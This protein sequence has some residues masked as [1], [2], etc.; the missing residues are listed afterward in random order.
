MVRSKNS[1]NVA[2]KN[3]MDLCLCSAIFWAVGYG[4]MFGSSINLE[5]SVENGVCGKSG[6]KRQRIARR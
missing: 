6:R 3:L 1:I 5:K 4:I 2:I